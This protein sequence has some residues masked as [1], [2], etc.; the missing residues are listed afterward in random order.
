MLDQ[1]LVEKGR[2]FA[3]DAVQKQ[4]LFSYASAREH[5]APLQLRGWPETMTDDLKAAVDALAAFL[6]ARGVSFDEAKGLTQEE[7]AARSDGKVLIRVLREALIIVLK[8]GPVEGVSMEQ[9]TNPGSALQSTKEIAAYLNAI[10]PKLVPVDAQLGR[11]FEGQKASE[12]VKAAWER[13]RMADMTQEQARKDL[14]QETLALLELKGRVIDLVEELN[15]VARIAFEGQAE[16]RAKF[17]K[18]LL[19]HG[20]RSHAKA[21]PGDAPGNAPVAPEA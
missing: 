5:Q 17:N 7:G 19:Y 18:D 12:L 14:P 6:A 15:G 2:Q 20:R 13:L 21:A 10:G 3:V 9:F 11:F 16:L 8:K 1:R 4:G